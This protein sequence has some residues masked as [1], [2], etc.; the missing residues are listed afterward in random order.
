LEIAN[1]A[2]SLF[3]VLPL[4]AKVHHQGDKLVLLLY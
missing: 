4:F 3:H 2:W 1:L